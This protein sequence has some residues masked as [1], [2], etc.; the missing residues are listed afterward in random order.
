MDCAFH[1]NHKP[2]KKKQDIYEFIIS[3]NTVTPYVLT[4]Q[5][6]FRTPMPTVMPGSYVCGVFFLRPRETLLTSRH[7][8][9]LY[10]KAAAHL[11]CFRV[12]Y[13]WFLSIKL[14][15]CGG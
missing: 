6:R 4:C 9:V 5:V 3:L 14:D 13:V 11:C 7:Y 10:Y 2:E 1:F 15:W 12:D 8:L